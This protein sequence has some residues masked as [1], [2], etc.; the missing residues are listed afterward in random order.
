MYQLTR[1]EVKQLHTETISNKLRQ[2]PSEEMRMPKAT[3]AN[4][5]DE[6]SGEIL[7]L[8]YP[9]HYQVGMAL[10]DELRQRRLTRKQVAILWLIRSIGGDR[11]GLSRKQIQQAITNWFEV[12]NSQ[13]TKA[14][15]A[16][17]RPPLSLIQIVEDPKSAREKQ[18]L[19]TAKGERFLLAM[20]ERGRAFFRPVGERLAPDL[21]RD[22]L[23]FLRQASA[24][25][26]NAK[27]PPPPR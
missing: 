12:S 18:V 4:R 20:V 25:L 6:L 21:I 14:L 13:I 24:A 8:F 5:H 15:R 10:E 1:S 19:L 3:T 9:V 23:V 16:M 7:E 2:S 11:R 22:G 17:A 26:E 27:S